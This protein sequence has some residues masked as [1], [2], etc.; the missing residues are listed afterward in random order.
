MDVS[1]ELK[2]ILEG[3]KDEAKLNN[4]TEVSSFHILSSLLNN[5]Y[6]SNYIFKLGGCDMELLMSV[7]NERIQQIKSNLTLNVDQI[8]VASKE[9]RYLLIKGI[10]ESRLNS[11]PFLN[12]LDFIR[13]LVEDKNKIKT[14][15]NLSGGDID[16]ILSLCQLTEREIE[17]KYNSKY[18]L[19]INMI[20]R[21]DEFA[22]DEK[23]HIRN[24]KDSKV[25]ALDTF[26][27]NLNK[28]AKEGKLQ[29]VIGRD[30]EIERMIL[31]L[32]RKTKK[33]PIIIGEA[34]VGKTALAEGL[35]LKIHNGDVH[36][37]LQNKIIYTLDLGLVVAGTKFRGDFEERIKVIVKELKDNPNII[38]FIDEI[39]QLIGSGSSSG[40]MD[41]ANLIKPELSRG[42]IQVIGATTYKEY[43]EHIESD[44]AIKRRF[45]KINLT[46]PTIDQTIEILYNIKHHY[47]SF[48]NVSIDKND[49]ELMV[50][51]ADRYIHGRYFPDKAIDVMD[52]VSAMTNLNSVD[53]EALTTIK[54]EITKLTLEKLDI[55][56][57]IGKLVVDSSY[58]EAAIM[59]NK[60][61][62]TILELTKLNLSKENLI[63][64]NGEGN[65]PNKVDE[66]TILSVVSLM[67]GVPIKKL[68]TDNIN[69]LLGV[70]TTLNERVIGQ[71]KAVSVM[72]DAIIRYKTGV[73][74]PNKPLVYLFMGQTGVGKTLL[75][76]EIAKEVYGSES[77]FIRINMSDYQDSFTVS[78]ITGSAKGYVGS[79]SGSF[80]Y[81]QVKHN[82]NSIILL[83]EVEKAHKNV[84]NSFLQ[85]FD[86][87]QAITNDG[88]KIS[89][90][91]AI[92]VMTSN[93]GVVEANQK[94]NSL[95]IGFNKSDTQKDVRQA[96]DKALKDKFSP[97]I[98]NRISEVV[99]FENINKSNMIKIVELELGRLEKR[100]NDLNKS[101]TFTKKLKEYL[102]ETGFSEEYG[103]RYLNREI[104][105]LVESPL[106]IFLLKNPE[107]TKIKIDYSNGEL[108][109]K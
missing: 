82:P 64:S 94:R 95:N 45:Q 10:E 24:S 14:I 53:E 81:E 18:N 73:R 40:S 13:I 58:E 96:Y 66:D 60:L 98:I 85:I 102:C 17:E 19:G 61:T 39:H 63:K 88:E 77:N 11:K 16:E 90:K 83:D 30:K 35:A 50:K 74:N 26:G 6:I 103:A 107:N 2:Q 7:T 34:G 33:N 48:H 65:N 4:H 21:G 3:A 49:I 54:T 46:E 38:V 15:I 23:I 42:D 28:L 70:E 79:E 41:G 12:I 29:E 22:S 5:N 44:S 109:I 25:K 69:Y 91:D 93:L 105:K 87:G 80:L 99:I 8:I 92:I 100:I 56:E 9:V 72:V 31:I 59:R 36:E 97:E 71:E 37:F 52:E 89:F 68:N 76:K 43:K 67:S 57:Q 55:E 32:M 86:E 20:T 84:F 104:E 106:S 62:K 108:V 101:V 78:N 47:E 27:V 75:V 51:L 1:Q